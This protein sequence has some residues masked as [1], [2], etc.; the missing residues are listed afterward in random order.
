MR[1]LLKPLEIHEDAAGGITGDILL[2]G[3]GVERLPLL[4]WDGRTLRL[5]MTPPPTLTLEQMPRLVL[6]V[7]GPDLLGNW[8]TTDTTVS[9]ISMRLRRLVGTD[10]ENPLAP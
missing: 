5:A 9:Q 1:S 10:V 8:E 2:H 6:R 3:G 7:V 4:E